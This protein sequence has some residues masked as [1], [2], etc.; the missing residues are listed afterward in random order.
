V[1]LGCSFVA[2]DISSKAF[3]VTKARATRANVHF[4]VVER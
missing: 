1:A 2:S 4:D 3:E